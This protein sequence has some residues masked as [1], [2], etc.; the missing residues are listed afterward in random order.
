MSTQQ[1]T[2]K[3]QDF[4]ASD[5]SFTKFEENERS[6][7]QNLAFPRFK[8]SQRLMLQG[9]WIDMNAYGVPQL[10]EYYKTDKD[11][12][13]I[14]IPLD[15]NNPEVKEF[16]EK[17]QSIDELMSSKEF[18]AQQFGDKAKK[19]KYAYP[20]CRVPIDDDED[21]DKKKSK[22][23]RPP[24][25]K[26]KLDATWPET[27]ILTQVF[28][29]VMKDGK[30]EREKQEVESVD[31]FANVVRYLSKI[32]PIISPVKA[33][34]E[35]KGK[36]GKDFLEYGITFKLVKV[37]V[38]PH[39]G[40]S[41][42][43]SSY[44]NNDAFIDS[45]DEDAD[46]PKFQG[47]PAAASTAKITLPL[48]KNKKESDDE[49]EEEKEESEAEESEPEEESEEEPEPEPVKPVKGKGAKAAPKKK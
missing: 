37:E 5:L 43:L 31:D 22:Y 24:Y 7:A 11:R 29:S 42:N 41:S 48:I 6:K 32:R 49:D 40:N 45:D 17:L 2:T 13:F 34:C 25:M 35:K 9:P 46:K 10:G 8:E 39:V 26:V 20:I 38:E 16:Y 27:K 21:E 14:K 12:A 47:K 18:K 44:M 4:N 28:T 33:W 15:L 19:Y 1:T 30:R 23:P 3:F 36:M